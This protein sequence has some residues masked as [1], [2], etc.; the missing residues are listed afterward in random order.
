ME[1]DDAS[2]PLIPS[3]AAVSRA[4]QGGGEGEGEGER[5]MSKREKSETKVLSFFTCLFL[6]LF[7]CEEREKKAILPFSLLH[8]R[9]LLSFILEERAR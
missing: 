9:H 2:P 3:V 6:F 5:S 8:T 4:R 7:F 1:I